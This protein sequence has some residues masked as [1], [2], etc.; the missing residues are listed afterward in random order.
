MDDLME[1]VLV[2]IGAILFVFV[3]ILMFVYL[4]VGLYAEA[5]CLEKGYPK[6]E[7][8]VG[9]ETYCMNLG[10]TVTVKVDKIKDM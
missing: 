8:T 6:S 2:T 10:G 9:L 7:V 5:K 1:K 3:F 4:P